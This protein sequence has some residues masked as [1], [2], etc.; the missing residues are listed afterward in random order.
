MNC[1][2]DPVFFGGATDPEPTL[3]VYAQQVPYS[4]EEYVGYLKRRLA[5][6]TETMA[7]MKAAGADFVHD[8]VQAGLVVHADVLL[9][10]YSPNSAADILRALNKDDEFMNANGEVCQMM[11]SFIASAVKLTDDVLKI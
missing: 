1:F 3:N 2:S 10:H 9:S 8:F 7:N 5:A 4:P 11:W 6:L